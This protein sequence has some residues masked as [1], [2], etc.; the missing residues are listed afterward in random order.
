MPPGFSV[1][2]AGFIPSH[3]QEKKKTSGRSVLK[4]AGGFL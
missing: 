1:C 4:S 3:I 2:G